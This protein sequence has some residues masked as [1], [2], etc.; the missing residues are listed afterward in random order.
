MNRFS[1]VTSAS[2]GVSAVQANVINSANL[3][4]Y[5]NYNNTVNNIINQNS[6]IPAPRQ[7]E[8]E[9]GQPRFGEHGNVSTST[10]V[11]IQNEGS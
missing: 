10:A 7:E 2:G 5:I 6:N 8:V 3:A 1:T 4:N 11:Y 9:M